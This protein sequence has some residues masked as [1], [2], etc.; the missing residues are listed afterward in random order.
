MWFP[1]WAGHLPGDQHLLRVWDAPK[2]R[3][4]PSG[5]VG[6]KATCLPAR[7]Y[8][9]LPRKCFMG[10]G[11]LDCASQLP[12]AVT[13]STHLAGQA[14]LS[15]VFI[16]LITSLPSAVVFVFKVRCLVQAHWLWEFRLIYTHTSHHNFKL[17]SHL[18]QQFH[19]QN[20]VPDT[21]PH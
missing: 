16:R 15:Q 11:T 10:G 12:S 18:N 1:A 3:A 6:D 21:V 19:F 7:S 14:H 17:V 2:R 13:P 9:W 4:V 8:P 5:R 20:S